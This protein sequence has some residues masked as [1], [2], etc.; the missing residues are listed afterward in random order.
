MQEMERQF[1]IR[2]VSGDVGRYCIL[3]GEPGRCASIAALFDDAKLI[4]QNREYT[5]YT[6]NLMGE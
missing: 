5:I 3:P 2:C 1:H 4:S 6:G